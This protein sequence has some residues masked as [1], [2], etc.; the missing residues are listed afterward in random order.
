MICELT[1]IHSAIIFHQL[2]QNTTKSII[3][4]QEILDAED[5]YNAAI[6]SITASLDKAKADI[7]TPE[8]EIVELERKL[9]GACGV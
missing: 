2:L 9:V 8:S 7:S 5:K 3:F 1:I 4:V 6:E